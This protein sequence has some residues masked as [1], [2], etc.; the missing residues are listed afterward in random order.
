MAESNQ[1]T[2]QPTNKNTYRE[3]LEILLPREVEV[4]KLV[5]KGLSNKA[6]AEELHLSIRTIHAH[7]RN[8]CSKLNLKG[9]NGLVK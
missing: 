9:R 6:I 7:R 3:A 2:N 5:G 8:I 4:L 1:P